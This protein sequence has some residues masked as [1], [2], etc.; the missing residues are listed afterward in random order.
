LS[1]YVGSSVSFGGSALPFAGGKDIFVT[2]LNSSGGLVWARTFGSARDDKAYG[3]AVGI[4][5]DVAVG[6]AF[7]DTIDFGNGAIGYDGYASMFL[8]KLS[9]ANGAAQWSQ[10][11]GSTPGYAPAVY[12]VAIDASGN[13]ALTGS[14]ASLTS[15]G[16]AYLSGDATYNI[17]VAKFTPAG[18]HLW[19]KTALGMWDDAGTAAAFDP[20]GN[21]VLTGWFLSQLNWGTGLINTGGCDAP[22]VKIG[23]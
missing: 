16:G 17:M 3:V 2:K 21:L 7:Y 20:S 4:D 8:T 13:I 14:S 12:A 19:S 1:G 18:N 23:L 11:Y 5:G 6:G 22:L 9:S 10:F 15:F